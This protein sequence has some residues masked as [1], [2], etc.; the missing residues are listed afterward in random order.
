MAS[1][2]P[3]LLCFN[4]LGG[5]NAEGEYEIRLEGEQLPPTPWTNVIANPSAG[6]MSSESG[7]GVT[8]AVNSSFFRL[9]PWE[10]D[11]VCDEP[12]E[13]I[14][15]LDDESGDLW[16]ATPAPIRERTPYVTRHGAGYTIFDH[17][18]DGIETSLRAGMAETDPVK[19]QL[20]SIKNSS[21]RERRLTITSYV[22]WLIGTDRER[23]QGHVQ[24]EMLP[25]ES[26]M[27][28]ANTF[29]FDYASQVAFA[30]ISEDLT[31]FTT[32]RRGFIGRNGS[33]SAPAGLS[34]ELDK[35]QTDSE[36]CSAMQIN[37]SLAPNQT[38]EIAVLL[39][40]VEGRS[41]ALALAT[42]YRQPREALAEL[43]KSKSA[44]RKRLDTIK[45]TT[46]E[47]TFDLIVNQWALYQSLSC[48]MW[49]RIALY[50]SSGAYGFRDQLQDS[51]AFVYAEQKLAREHIMFASSRQFEEGDVQ[52]WWHPD[53][54]R[55]VR[56]RFA[57]DL[58]W[59]TYV[60]NHYLRVTGDTSVLDEVTP[61]VSLRILDEH[62]EEIYD[63]PAISTR[64]DSV[65]THCVRAL[66]RACT[67]GAHGLPLIGGGDWNDGM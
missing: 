14:Y 3:D 30:A 36:P 27:L 66:R 22:D 9:T 18:H 16:T 31:S 44:W 12:G 15:L 33:L 50:Q 7:F 42:R 61:Y 43:D 51:M 4:G 37:I 24:T 21:S 1:R 28:A 34:T 57:D 10:N 5:F 59:L 58:I 55:G 64:S 2:G 47:P 40:A 38:R 39:G 29:D 63:V 49:G 23:T 48:R 67:A 65:Y 8:W 41:E 53:S 52:H 56:T 60:I 19:I 6:F 11:P 13:C 54:G 35:N 45:V 46:P 20:L 17:E 62:E 26:T 32:D 25:G